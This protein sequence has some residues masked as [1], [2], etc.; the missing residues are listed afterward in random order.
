MNSHS[1]FKIRLRSLLSGKL[2]FPAH[3]L[4]SP[5]GASTI[6]WVYS[7]MV[8][9]PGI[10]GG[11]LATAPPGPLAAYTRAVP[12]PSRVRGTQQE[13]L[14]TP[15][16]EV[17][18]RW[19]GVASGHVTRRLSRGRRSPDQGL[20]WPGQLGGRRPASHGRLR[21]LVFSA[22]GDSARWAGDSPMALAPV[23]PNVRPALPHLPAQLPIPVPRQF[24]RAAGLLRPG[25]GLPALP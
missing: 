19:R 23:H 3:P 13:L 1:W 2:S 5:P 10:F 4:P 9:R 18:G 7:S 14:V 17:R 11:T 24:G 6:W 25:R 22:A 21:A 16:A 20:T 15:G 8:R 12:T